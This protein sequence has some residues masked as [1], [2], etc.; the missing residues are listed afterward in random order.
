MT[1]ANARRAASRWGAVGYFSFDGRTDL[2]VAIRTMTIGR[3][4]TARFN[5]GGGIVAE[6]DPRRNTRS[7]SSRR[8]P[9]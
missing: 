6:S 2:S 4:R 7:R 1:T 5:V 9:C 3:D 8:A